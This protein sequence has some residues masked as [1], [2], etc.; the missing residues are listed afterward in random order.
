[1]AITT[2]GGS[3]VTTISRAVGVGGDHNLFTTPN[4]PNMMFIVTIIVAGGC[5]VGTAVVSNAAA[6]G[7]QASV[8]NVGTWSGSGAGNNN[9]GFRAGCPGNPGNPGD[10]GSAAASDD[11]IVVSRQTVGP[12]TAVHVPTFNSDITT[13]TIYVAWNYCG[14]SF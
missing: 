6:D 3:G 12:N 1:M 10:P 8:A 4:T 13:R 2:V 9:T 14:I 5:E 7:A 11:H